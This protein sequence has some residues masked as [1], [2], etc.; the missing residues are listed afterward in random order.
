MRWRRRSTDQSERLVAEC[1]AF[2]EGR[3]LEHLVEAGCLAVPTWA[4]TNALAHG[5]AARLRT[6]EAS[7][8]RKVGLAPWCEARL[9][10][11]GEVRDTARRIGSLPWV[12]ELALVP[13]ELE[14]ARRR[15]VRWWGPGQWAA[16]V[17]DALGVLTLQR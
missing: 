10:V 9:Y 7:L 6:L 11:A 16:A 1:E 2:L 3:Y 13:L 4:W 15:D 17:L 5:D 14:L 12:Q 8:G